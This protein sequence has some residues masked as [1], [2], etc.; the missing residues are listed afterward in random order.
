[1]S[2]LPAQLDSATNI[3]KSYEKNYFTS[4]NFF[5]SNTYYLEHK[6]HASIRLFVVT[7]AEATQYVSIFNE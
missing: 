4:S 2:T 7:F 6:I 5:I 1:M 3:Y